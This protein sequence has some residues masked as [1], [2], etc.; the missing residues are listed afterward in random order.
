M[1]LRKLVLI[2]DSLEKLVWGSGGP[3]TALLE[4][5]KLPDG[6]AESYCDLVKVA[7]DYLFTSR[8]W[9]QRLFRSLHFASCYLPLRYEVWIAAGNRPSLQTRQELGEIGQMQK[10]CSGTRCLST[11]VLY[12]SNTSRGTREHCLLCHLAIVVRWS[13]PVILRH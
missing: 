2:N 12:S 10:Y 6:W 7:E 13:S 5:G 4:Q 11:I 1:A 8:R 3:V 9:S